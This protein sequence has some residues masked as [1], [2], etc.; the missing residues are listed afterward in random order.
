MLR[1]EGSTPSTA[2]NTQKP[3]QNGRHFPDSIFKCIFMHENVEGAI[4]ISLKFVLFPG[5]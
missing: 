1:K 2:N 3:R 5:V 4:V